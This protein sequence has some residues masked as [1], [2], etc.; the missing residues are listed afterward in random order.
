MQV[1]SATS[2]RDMPHVIPAFSQH[3]WQ[4]TDHGSRNKV[5]ILRRNIEV[6]TPLKKVIMKFNFVQ[7]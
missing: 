1:P 5:V 3:C 7:T 2:E 6:K 4:N